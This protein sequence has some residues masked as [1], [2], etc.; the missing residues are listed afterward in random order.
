MQL[1]RFLDAEIEAEQRDPDRQLFEGRRAYDQPAG[2]VVDRLHHTRP[3]VEPSLAPDQVIGIQVNAH[4]TFPTGDPED[5]AALTECERGRLAAFKDFQDDKSG[6][7]QIQGTPPLTASYGLI[8]SPIAQLAWITEKFKDWTD[9]KAELPDDAFD[10]DRL[11]TN[12]SI[13]WFTG[14]ALSSANAYYERFHDASAWAPK[15]RS[16]VPT[17][18]AVFTTD[19]AIRRFAEK[20]D[21]IVRWTE[22]ERGGHFAAMEAPDLLLGDVREFVRSLT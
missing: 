2:A 9:P 22:F 7:M 17:A 4:V 15:E 6:Y 21:T 8:D 16:T 5:I 12:I 20:T 10:R 14:T 13:Y 19:V 11:L 18:V 3:S 1:R